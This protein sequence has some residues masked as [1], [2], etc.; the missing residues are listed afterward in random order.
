MEIDEI[1]QRV[2]EDVDIPTR[3]KK[4]KERIKAHLRT[5]LEFAILIIIIFVVFRLI[6]GMSPVEGDSMYP[7]LHDKDTVFYNK[8]TKDYVR[9]DIVAIEMPGGDMYVKRIIGVVG[10]TVN[11]NDGKVYVNGKEVKEPWAY[12][13]TKSTEGGLVYPV[14][15]KEGQVF[16][17]GDNREVSDDS[18]MFGPVNI[19]DTQGKLLWYVGML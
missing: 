14:T 9:G 10:D 18:R 1:K 4:R 13:E 2:L 15:V 16:V 17:L 12:G 6:V 8:L 7:T 11:L 19:E 5:L 3:R